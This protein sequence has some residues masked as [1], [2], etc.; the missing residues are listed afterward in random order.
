[1]NLLGESLIEYFF[2]H[3]SG[4]R[5]YVRFLKNVFVWRWNKVD[6][7]LWRENNRE[8]EYCVL[9]GWEGK[10]TFMWGLHIFHPAHT[11]FVSLKWRKYLVERVWRWNEQSPIALLIFLMVLWATLTPLFLLLFFLYYFIF[12]IPGRGALYSFFV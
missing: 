12:W 7:K 10:K 11:K 2:P 3:T 6:E 9:F 8:N 5:N 1:M 4:L